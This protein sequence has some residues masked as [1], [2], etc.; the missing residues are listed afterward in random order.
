MSDEV[1]RKEFLDKLFD[2]MTK[3]GTN[4]IT[5]LLILCVATH[6]MGCIFTLL[7][8]SALFKGT[9]ITR[10]PIMAKQPLDMYRLFKLVVERGG[11]VEVKEYHLQTRLIFFLFLVHNVL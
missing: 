8:L 11:L 7:F 4:S 3:K 1:E 5:K 10:I 2:Y 9:P 6:I